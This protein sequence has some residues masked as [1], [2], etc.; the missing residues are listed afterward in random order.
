[1][2]PQVYGVPSR[3]NAEAGYELDVPLDVLLEVKKRR[4][5]RRVAFA[6]YVRAGVRRWIRGPSVS[7]A[8]PSLTNASGFPLL[9]GKRPRPDVFA[10]R[11]GACT[12]FVAARGKKEPATSTG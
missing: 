5:P 7:F 11:S 12:S 10:Y 1:M 9:A 3:D 8:L 2:R 6:D 4:P